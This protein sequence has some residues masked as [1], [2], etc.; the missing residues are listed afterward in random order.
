MK[1]QALLVALLLLVGSFPSTLLAGENDPLYINLT[2][3]DSHRIKMALAQGGK[4]LKLGHP[5]TIHLNDKGVFLAVK[6]QSKRYAS[7]QAKLKELAG[8]G[9]KIIVCPMCLKHHRQSKDDLLS[10]VELGTPELVSEVLFKDGT[11]TLTW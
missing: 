5:L 7:L 4:M 8:Q 9:A 3:S 2:T 11:K 6:S 1:I 10:V